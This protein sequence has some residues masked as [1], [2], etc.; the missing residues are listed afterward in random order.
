MELFTTS[1]AALR[2]AVHELPE[3]AF[4]LPSGCR[5]WLV[6]DLVGHL[7]IDAQDVLITL[8]TPA[9]T[10]PTA[11]ALSCWTP[12]PTPPDGTDPHDA[13]TV[14]LAAAYEDPGLLR[15]HLEDL[16]GAAERAALLAEPD[17]PVATQ[18]MSLTVRDYLHAYVLE[19]TLHHLDLLA[20]L[21]PEDAAAPPPV[22]GLAEARDMVER[23]LRVRLPAGWSDADALRRATGRE[24]LTDAQRAELEELGPRGEMLPL[25]FG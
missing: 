20:H 10:A 21:D 24:S 19:W 9:E 17:L 2:R 18:G 3:H 4:S 25:S 5:G 12:T 1:W 8:A 22:E 11:D 6:R 14:R 7:V 15:D 16:G 23:R 13:L